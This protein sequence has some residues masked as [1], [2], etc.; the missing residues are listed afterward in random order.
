MG[1]IKMDRCLKNSN[2]ISIEERDMKIIIINMI[3]AS[4][5]ITRQLI[6]IRILSKDEMG[7]NV[8]KVW[9]MLNWEHDSNEAIQGNAIQ[10]NSGGRRLLGKKDIITI[11]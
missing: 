5:I 6:R 8:Y 10:V 4:L 7:A 3:L 2:V 11:R 9:V 1:R